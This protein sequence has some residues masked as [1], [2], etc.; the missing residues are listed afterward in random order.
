MSISVPPTPRTR[1]DEP[2][3]LFDAADTAEPETWA[4]DDFGDSLDSV[5]GPGSELDLL[6][7]ALRAGGED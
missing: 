6:S 1:N 4:L 2:T 7:R 3:D 5:E